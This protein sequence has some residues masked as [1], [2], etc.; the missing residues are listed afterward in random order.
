MVG[1]V[2]LIEESSSRTRASEPA[3]ALLLAGEEAAAAALGASMR[4]RLPGILVLE[5]PVAAGDG[6]DDALIELERRGRPVFVLLLRGAAEN[7][8]SSPFNR[9]E[10]A[11]SRDVAELAAAVLAWAG[12]SPQS[13]GSGDHSR[14]LILLR[15]GEVDLRSPRF[16]DDRTS[17]LSRRGRAQ[18]RLAAQALRPAAPDLV[19]TS[20]FSRAR[21]SAA[22]V[23]GVLECEVVVN[24]LLN[25]RAFPPLYGL[26]TEE[27]LGRYG[28][29]FLDLLN[30][31]PDHVVLDGVETLEQASSRIATLLDEVRRSGA[32]RPLLVGHGGP[33][34]WIACHALNL[35]VRLCR[36]F[37]TAPGGMS[38]FS[39]DPLRCVVWNSYHLPAA[40]LL[41]RQARLLGRA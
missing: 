32:R 39:L 22:I 10:A 40:A 17:R 5:R 33:F 2:R 19:F 34:S 16:P 24:P 3:P 13:A 26:T 23:G 18:I 21:E 25:E 38:V 6:L 36:R 14:L 20:G 7:A 12:A 9:V 11:G 15:H 30:S 4:K 27:I 8:E 31:S 37:T 29:D 41:T 35:D 28:Q 1:I